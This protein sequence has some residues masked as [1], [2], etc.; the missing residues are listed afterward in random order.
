FGVRCVLAT[1]DSGGSGEVGQVV[2]VVYP[3]VVRTELV[4]IGLGRIHLQVTVRITAPTKSV[5]QEFIEEHT[6]F[7][8]RPHHQAGIEESETRFVVLVTTKFASIATDA[9]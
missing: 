5:D 7:T 2:E 8:I 9:N 1:G 6:R 4:Q 3:T